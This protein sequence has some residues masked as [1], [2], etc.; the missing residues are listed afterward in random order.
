MIEGTSK[1]QQS[2][3]SRCPLLP[4]FLLA[5]NNSHKLKEFRDFFSSD[6]DNDQLLE[7]NQDNK[8]PSI[9]ILSPSDLQLNFS[10]EETGKTFAENSSIK[11][12]ALF[13]LSGLPSIADDSGICIEEL[14]G[15]P[16]VHSARYG[17]DGLTDKERCLLL[18]EELKNSTNRKA[19]FECVISL[20]DKNGIKF[21][22]G[23]CDGEIATEYDENGTTFGYDPIFYYPPLNK[24]FSR[25]TLE[26]KNR[27]SHRGIAME[28]LKIIFLR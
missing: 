24:L 11:S 5:T 15:R 21:F 28:K 8:F 10:V 14:A 3:V 23:R 9:K 7:T 1:N 22:T 12:K 2:S 27:I 18:L 13:S 25:L 6:V 19:W 20:A 17:G 16:G 4:E 26:E